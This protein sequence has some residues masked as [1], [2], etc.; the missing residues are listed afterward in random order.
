MKQT[1]DNPWDKVEGKYPIGSEITGISSQPHQLRCVYRTRRGHRRLA[2]RLRYVLD[3]KDQPS[4]RGPGK[5]SGGKLQDSGGRYRPSSDCARLKTDEDDP[6]NTDIPNRYTPGQIIK[7]NVTKITN[8]GVFVGLEDGLEGLLHISELAE[9]KVDNPEDVVNVGDELEV[10][11]LRVDTEDRKIG[12]SRRRVDWSEEQEARG[13]RRSGKP[14]K[15]VPT[16]VTS[17]HRDLKG[18]L[19]GSGPLIDTSLASESD[20]QEESSE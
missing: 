5:R 18:G 3:Q 15:R 11:V 19:G 17:R 10:K 14:K 12:L 4:E 9:H 2:A 6:W 20:K 7:G 8:F 16:P 1:Q 13:M